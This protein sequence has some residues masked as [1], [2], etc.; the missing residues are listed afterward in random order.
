MVFASAPASKTSHGAVRFSGV[1]QITPNLVCDKCLAISA[2]QRAP[3]KISSEDIHG[4]TIWMTCFNQTCRHCATYL[5]RSPDQLMKTS[6]E[7][8][9]PDFAHRQN[10]VHIVAP[11]DLLQLSHK[12]W[13][14]RSVLPPPDATG[15][16]WSNSNFSR[17][18]HFTHC[19]LSLCQ[20]KSRTLSGI[21]SRDAP[22]SLSIFS[23]AS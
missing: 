10:F 9:L 5:D 17:S 22:S 8:F 2:F 18:P 19:P 13:T 14:F 12:S 6:I 15:M 16:M 11:F 4:F 3:A 1:T 7:L 23:S 20:T 21:G